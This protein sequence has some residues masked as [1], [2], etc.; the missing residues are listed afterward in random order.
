V[1]RASDP[2]PDHAVE[3]KKLHLRLE[4]EE[5]QVEEENNEWHEFRRPSGVATV[6]V[7][8]NHC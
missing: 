4:E 8:S 6:H 7:T 5:V 3:R 1:H 2:I